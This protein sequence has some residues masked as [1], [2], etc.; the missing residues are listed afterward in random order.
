MVCKM[1]LIFLRKGHQNAMRRGRNELPL[2]NYG[3]IQLENYTFSAVPYNV[4]FENVA[5][6]HPRMALQ[7]EVIPR[8]GAERRRKLNK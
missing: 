7:G 5:L 3:K 8:K 1:F 4:S 2:Q 6:A